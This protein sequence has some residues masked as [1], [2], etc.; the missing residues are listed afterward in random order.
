MRD[1]AMT[2]NGA[3]FW[4]RFANRYAARQIKDTDAY[5][6]LLADVAM[7]L[8]ATDN[9][10]EIGC[11]T[12]GMAI[13]LAPAV[14]TLRATD[15]SQQMIRIAKEKPA[16]DNLRFEVAT[17]QTALDGGPFDAICA[18]N[19]LHLVD[20][21]PSLL[22]DIYQGL[23]P[24]GLLISKTWCFADLGWR[25]RVLFA[26]LKLFGLFPPATFLTQAQL[27]QMLRDAGFTI[28][29]HRVFGT[30]LQNPYFVAYK[31]A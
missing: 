9:V 31:P 22:R 7:R 11:G 30:R 27:R 28:G 29:E 14:A 23:T 24:G 10:L 26:V 1:A 25:P 3:R 13:R 21:L 18:F 5:D 19:V 2:A 4:N 20:D 12:G 16:P 15:F 17:A 8:R 6:A